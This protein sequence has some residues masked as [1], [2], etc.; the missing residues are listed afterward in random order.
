MVPSDVRFQETCVSWHFEF[1]CVA[2]H[3]MIV[4]ELCFT[5]LSLYQSLEHLIGLIYMLNCCCLDF[6]IYW[7]ASE[8]TFLILKLRWLSCNLCIH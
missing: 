7:A 8:L 2:T 4:H 3:L 1:K 6:L 5:G